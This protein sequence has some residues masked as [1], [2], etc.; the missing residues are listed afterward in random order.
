[1]TERLELPTRTCV[2]S[3]ILKQT[4][5]RAQTRIDVGFQSL[6]GTSRAPV[7]PR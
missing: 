5:A 1:V 3:D 4:S 7:S 6:A 2:L